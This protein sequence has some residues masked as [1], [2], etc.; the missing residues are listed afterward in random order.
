MSEE[1]FFSQLQEQSVNSITDHVKQIFKIVFQV[2]KN[3]MMVFLSIGTTQV[4]P[5]GAVGNI[6]VRVIK[7]MAQ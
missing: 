5:A 6:S 7:A 1:E 4:A 2:E 3:Y